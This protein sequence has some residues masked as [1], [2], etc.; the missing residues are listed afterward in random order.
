METP[1]QRKK[2]YDAIKEVYKDGVELTSRECAEILKKQ[3]LCVYGTRQEVQP[4]LSEMCKIGWI[5]AVGSK[6]DETTHKKVTVYAI[7]GTTE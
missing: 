2:F 4:R 7:G 3:G 1:V 5:K 6:L